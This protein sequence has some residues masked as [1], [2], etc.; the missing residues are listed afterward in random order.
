MT[1][2]PGDIA[3]VKDV[4]EQLLDEIDNM[5]ARQSILMRDAVEGLKAKAAEVESFL[6]TRALNTLEGQPIKVGD[7]IY[8]PKTK[9]KWRTN[10]KEVQRM[11]AT[12][13]TI[14]DNGEIENDP[15]KAALN[16]IRLTY[17]LFVS[18]SMVPKSG[19]LESNFKK[20]WR[21][22]AD[23]ERTGEELKVQTVEVEG[24]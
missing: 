5:D 15:T 16:A 9:G 10:H 24:E 6:T 4:L 2:S 18:P 14:D 11:I 22:I 20:S 13:A 19:Q 1:I 17:D 21:D 23:W 12:H 7:K 8:F 3:A